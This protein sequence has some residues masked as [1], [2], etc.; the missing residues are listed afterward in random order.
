ME[1]WSEAKDLAVFLLGWTSSGCEIQSRNSLSKFTLG[2]PMNMNPTGERQSPNLG[3]WSES[4]NQPRAAIA[5]YL[6]FCLIWRPSVSLGELSVHVQPTH[7]P[8]NEERGHVTQGWS[9]TCR[10]VC[11]W[12][13]LRKLVIGRSLCSLSLSSQIAGMRWE[14][15]QQRSERHQEGCQRNELLYRVR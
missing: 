2:G 5:I 11:A 4:L 10:Q 15:E 6:L 9:I 7:P 3:H 1:G 14:G 13:L 8:Y 12:K